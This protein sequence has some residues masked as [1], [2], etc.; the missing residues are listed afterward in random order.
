M[1]TIISQHKIISYH[2]TFGLGLDNH[3]LKLCYHQL[4]PQFL[5]VIATPL[6]LSLSK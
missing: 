1:H 6:S 4:R 3:L 5:V 2:N